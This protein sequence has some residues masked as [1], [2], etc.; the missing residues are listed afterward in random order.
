MTGLARFD[1]P[2]N[3]MQPVDDARFGHLVLPFEIRLL[4]GFLALD[5]SA[6]N[7]SPLFLGEGP[8]DEERLGG[9]RLA[10]FTGLSTLCFEPLLASAF[11]VTPCSTTRE[12]CGDFF[13]CFAP[14]RLAGRCAACDCLARDFRGAA[15]DPSVFSSRFSGPSWETL[16]LRRLV[17][18][19][20]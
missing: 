11:F 13:P 8:L 10:T 5:R 16:V 7:G 2:A 4:K 14:D 1:G 3:R 6:V 20:V 15:L 12:F 9:G 19:F 18:R 17:D